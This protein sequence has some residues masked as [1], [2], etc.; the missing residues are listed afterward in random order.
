MRDN[1]N[2]A[3][4]KYRLKKLNSETNIDKQIRRAKNNLYMRQYR[5]NKTN[6]ITDEDR[7]IKQAKGK[8]LHETI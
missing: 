5:Q 7:Q 8:C 1:K 4:K 3:M 6:N 2:V